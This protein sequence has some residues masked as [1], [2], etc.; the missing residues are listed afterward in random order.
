VDAKARDR[1]A[2]PTRTVKSCG[3]DAPTLAFKFARKY[4]RGDGD[5]KARSPAIECTHLYCSRQRRLI[6]WL[7]SGSRRVILC[8]W[9]L[10]WDDLVIVAW[11]KGGLVA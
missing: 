11:K 10:D 2:A 9:R 8:R 7:V 4:P 3:P 5:N 1:R 6:P